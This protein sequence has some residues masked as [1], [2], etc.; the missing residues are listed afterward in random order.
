MRFTPLPVVGRRIP[1]AKPGVIQYW[2]IGLDEG[3]P[4][5]LLERTSAGRFEFG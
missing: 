4:K 1:G 2:L 5:A 3:I